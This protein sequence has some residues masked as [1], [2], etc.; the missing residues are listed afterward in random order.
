MPRP[1]SS[2]AVSTNL[3]GTLDDASTDVTQLNAAL[4]ALQA[5]LD[6]STAQIIVGANTIVNGITTLL[7]SSLLVT[8]ALKNLATLNGLAT[9]LQSLVA[10]LG[11]TNLQSVLKL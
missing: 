6:A 1:L 8:S 11:L 2:I 5:P 10:G 7:R 4:Q 3:V 9:T